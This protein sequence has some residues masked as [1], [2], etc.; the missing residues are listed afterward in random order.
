MTLTNPQSDISLVKINT[1]PTVTVNALYCELH[2]SG[3]DDL[4]GKERKARLMILLNMY[5]DFR[6]SDISP[7]LS[8]RRKSNVSICLSST[9]TTFALSGD[10]GRH[11]DVEEQLC[12]LSLGRKQTLRQP[13]PHRGLRLFAPDIRAQSGRKS[14]SVV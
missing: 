9:N 14:L 1:R 13:A 12:Q 4:I 6:A 3:L 5:H 11:D 10:V 8:G 2:M 7:Y